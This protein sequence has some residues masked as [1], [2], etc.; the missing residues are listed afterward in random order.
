M[1][2]WLQRLRGVV[3]TALTWA[4]GWC[5]AGMLIGTTGLFGN[6]ALV[7]YVI[8]GGVFAVLGFIG[9]TAFSVVLSL[10]EGRRRF[11]QMS[12]S[13]FAVWGAIGG[14]LMSLTVTALGEGGGLATWVFYMAL[15]SGSAAGS[16]A[17]ARRAEHQQLLESGEGI[18]EVGL[19]RDEARRL[20]GDQG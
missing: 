15:G 10:I 19:S 12:L 2:R 17:V 18:A 13:R 1:K 7:E 11:D 6:L 8:F 14:A 4:V 5:I 9:G 20:L 16:L 3:G